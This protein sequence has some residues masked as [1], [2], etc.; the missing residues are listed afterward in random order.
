M[1]SNRLL[2]L[3][4]IS[5]LAGVNPSAVANWRRRFKDFPAPIAELK[6]GPVFQEGLVRLW[7]KRRNGDEL[8][9]ALGFY[10]QL[11]AKRGDSPDLIANT[12]EIL[13]KLDD[14]STSTKRPGVL[15]GKVQSGK[16]RAFLGFV[17]GAF[18]RGYDVAIILTKGTKSLA[19]QTLTR[20]KE[21][22]SE[23]L[24]LD[25]VQVFDIMSLPELTPYEL[26]Q[27]LIFIVKKE[28]D[29]L[30][31]LLNAV[32]NKY[33]ALR[34]RKVLIIDDEA[35]VASVS[36]R[37]GKGGVVGV[38]IISRQIDKL[39]ELVL[40]S[41][42]LQV[43]ATPYSL[44]LQ[45]EEDVVNNGETLF[46]P[47]RPAFTVV[48]GTH[49][50]YVGG[51]Y[52]FERSTDPESPAYYFY[53]EVSVSERE[54]LK[55]EDRRRLRIENVMTERNAEVLR[56][57]I[58]GFVV[59]GTIRRLQQ[60]AE[61]VKQQKY[62]FLFHTESR[63]KSHEWQESVA[64]AIREA[65]IQ[66]AME[67]SPLFDQLLRTAY[68]DLKRS[69]SLEGSNVPSYETV[70]K[71]VVKSLLSGQL[72]ITK[73][74]S[75]KDIEELLD[76]DGQ[77]KLRTPFN[78]F[79]GGQIL[80][81]G[82]TINN[83]IGFYYGRNPQRF[84]QDT[85]LQHSRMY[86]ARSMAD[87]AVTRFYSPQHIFQIMKKIHEF[88]AALRE[89]FEVGAHERG[90]YFIQK[91]A[92]NRLVPCSP[93]KL[94]LSRVLS[95]RP[96]R[97]IVPIGFQTVSRTR[98]QKNLAAI[99]QLVNKLTKRP[100]EL[101][102]IPMEKA[103]ELLELAYRN[104][105]FEEAADDEHKAHI[106]ALEHL[107]QTSRDIKKRGKV[108]LLAV[109]DRNVARYREEGRFS[110]APDTK[111]QADLARSKAQ[112]IPVLMLLRQNGDLSKGW[113]DLPFWWPVIVAPRS[114]VTSIFATDQH[115][116]V[117]MA[118]PSK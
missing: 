99:D 32:E 15:L 5:E 8:T 95:I 102:E 24:A 93:N 72:M 40:D 33:P 92:A 60:L 46:H 112:D 26:N 47:K 63:R 45:P 18:D 50:Q 1:Q 10:D 108:L 79:I 41:D 51:D 43:T 52:Y 21:D 42:F 17:A 68:N 62:S 11:A 97:R 90:V 87:L 27:K 28:D 114:A 111:Q 115:A 86:G 101:T 35:D 98:G 56:E 94:L 73:V 54:A 107:S 81:R 105:E 53:R 69:V 113:R 65:L 104:L 109:T 64:A 6:S 110:N 23:F 20:V 78:M 39:R 37:R 76:D 22:F 75:D 106:A 67:D 44:Y 14:Q 96:G 34:Q 83:L 13:Q 12:Q 103:V 49:E 77:L 3:Y 100:N 25:Q 74:N 2:G 89:A 88:D 30:D 16:T 70:R 31:R 59:G 80:D 118:D 38:G 58:V 117:V 9:G 7:L 19:R 84:Q 71:E 36:F 116:D 85:V 55:L 48:L 57:A 61:N 29:N 66:G 82:I 91:D 4:E